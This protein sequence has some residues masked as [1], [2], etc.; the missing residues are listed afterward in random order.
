MATEAN[1][2]YQEA[3][4]YLCVGVT[5]AE[6]LTLALERRWLLSLNPAADTTPTA[7]LQYGACYSCYTEGSVFDVMELALLDQIQLAL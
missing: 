5:Q 1:T 4:C 7:L 6:A 2:L 3:A